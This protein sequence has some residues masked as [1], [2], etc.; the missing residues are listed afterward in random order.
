[1][2]PIFTL[3]APISPILLTNRSMECPSS[4]KFIATV[5]W[6][7]RLRSIRFLVYFL[8]MFFEN[9]ITLDGWL[10]SVVLSN[11]FMW[12]FVLFMGNVGLNRLHLDER[13][14]LQNRRMRCSKKL[15]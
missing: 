10:K 11:Q 6:F 14:N 15:G 7:D 12:I 2:L 13:K 4:G 1:M 3:S 5:V 9:G 8:T